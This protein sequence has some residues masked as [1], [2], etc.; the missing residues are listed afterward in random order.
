VEELPVPVVISGGLRS[1]ELAREA[2]ARTGAAAVALARGSLGN[3]WLFSQLLGQRSTEPTRAE[4]L[5]ELEWV[6]DRAAEHPAPSARPA[7]CAS[8]SVV[9]RAPRRR[10]RAQDAA[11]VPRRWTPRAGISA[12]PNNA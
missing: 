1:P 9:R 3:P 2:F 11:A 12:S 7:T 8:S 10:P 5:A 6:M 4:I